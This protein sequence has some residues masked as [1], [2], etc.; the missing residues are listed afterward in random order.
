MRI[1]LTRSAFH[2]VLMSDFYTTLSAV[3]KIYWHKL[4][5]VFALV[6]PQQPQKGLI[7]I[8]QRACEEA[9]STGKTLDEALEE[10]FLGAKERT[11]RRMVL[12]NQCNVK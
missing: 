12:L 1:A 9:R 10:H 4:A 2:Q 3:E 11:E 8:I 7:T 6:S 5:D